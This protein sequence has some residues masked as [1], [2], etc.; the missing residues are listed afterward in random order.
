MA[1]QMMED[2]DAS[3]GYT[4]GMGYGDEATDPAAGTLDDAYGDE[5]QQLQ[6]TD[7]D[8]DMMDL[9]SMPVTQEDAWAVIS[10]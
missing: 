1:D 2:V 6:Y 9:D 8:Q 7:N 3:Q 5:S 10:A 4:D